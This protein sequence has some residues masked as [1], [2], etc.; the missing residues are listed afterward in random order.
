MTGALPDAVTIATTLAAINAS[1]E[2]ARAPVMRHLLGYLVDETLAGRGD[3]LKAYSVAV[4]ALGRN[5]DF[6]AQTDSYPRVQVGRLRRMLDTFYA[7]SPPVPLRLVIPLGAYRVQFGSQPGGDEDTPDIVQ[8]AASAGRGLTSIRRYGAIA[9]MI[10]LVLAVCALAVFVW[11]GLGPSRTNPAPVIM[12]PPSLSIE[13]GD[14]A[15]SPAERARIGDVVRRLS[16]AFARSSI[17]EVSY[18]ARTVDARYALLLDLGTD[19][20]SLSLRLI[21]R[22][23]GKLDWADMITLPEDPAALGEAVRPSISALVRPSGIV[24]AAQ[25]AEFRD[26]FS[27]GYPC[28]LHYDAYF[29]EREPALRGP[30]RACIARTTALDPT[31]A[32]AL[33]AAS[34]LQIDPVDGPGSPAARTR[35]LVLARRASAANPSSP[36]AILA[37][38]RIAFITGNCIRGQALAERAVTLDGYDPETLG[39]AG[40]LTVQCD[41]A[42]ALDL[43]RGAHALD[44][45]LT[46]FYMSALVLLELDAGRATEAAAIAAGMRPPGPGMVRQYLVAQALGSIAR[47]DNARA[48]ALWRQAVELTGAPRDTVDAVLGHFYLAP[49]FRSLVAKRLAQAGIADA[50]A[51]R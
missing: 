7:T 11:R 51:P 39:L 34:F 2:F 15:Q 24:A 10:G 40:M 28:L 4:D 33:A 44:P 36:A 18:G 43:L 8:N 26:D 14:A 13:I 41:E 30:V 29:R 3:R 20:V 42:R 50:P 45:E 46:T 16:T 35:A 19:G 5:A 38:A 23:S 22:R 12:P 49:A 9:L 25:R 48:H 27:P 1:T 17:A 6:D 31:H 32:D 47:G 37:E 21:D